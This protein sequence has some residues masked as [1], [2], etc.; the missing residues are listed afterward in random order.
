MAGGA[1]LSGS[2]CAGMASNRTKSPTD[3][4]PRPRRASG[5][6][7]PHSPKSTLDVGRTIPLP[8]GHQGLP[9]MELVALRPCNARRAMA[10]APDTSSTSKETIEV[11]GACRDGPHNVSAREGKTDRCSTAIHCLDVE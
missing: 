5:W 2:S 8:F 6:L 9:H 10:R 7:I 1:V 4:Y 11:G 3:E